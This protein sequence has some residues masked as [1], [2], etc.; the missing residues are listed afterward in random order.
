MRKNI[1]KKIKN[2]RKISFKKFIY[3]LTKNKFP[4]SIWR[5]T[6]TVTA[7]ASVQSI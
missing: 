1:F 2:K 6:S 3:L 7:K 4:S 5:R